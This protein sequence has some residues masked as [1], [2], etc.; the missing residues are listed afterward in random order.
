MS[1][2]WMNIGLLSVGGTTEQEQEHFF[3]VEH[4]LRS[5]GE[6]VIWMYCCRLKLRELKIFI[7]FWILIPLV[8]QTDI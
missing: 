3:S 6:Q 1:F 2:N 8:L 5:I 7:F 4:D